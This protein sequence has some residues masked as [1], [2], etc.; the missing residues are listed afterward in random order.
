MTSP[1]IKSLELGR[2]RP[3][4]TACGFCGKKT[5]DLYYVG[6]YVKSRQSPGEKQKQYAGRSRTACDEC[7]VKEVRRWDN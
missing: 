5:D 3:R 6:M 2:G 1:L 4:A 7:A